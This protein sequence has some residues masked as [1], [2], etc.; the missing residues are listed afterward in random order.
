MGSITITFTPPEPPA[1]NGYLVKYRKVGDA[2]YSTVVPNQTTSPIVI[3]NVN[4]A[5][6]YEGTIQS[7]CSNGVLSTPITFLVEPCVGDDKKNINGVCTTGIRMNISSTPTG[8]PGE[9]S[10]TYT[11][12]FPDG[13]MSANFI[14]ISNVNCMGSE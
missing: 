8:N 3:N 10:C 2:N 14:E 1:I 4:N 13:S 6:S 11:Y 9:Y 5:F 7:D 12:M